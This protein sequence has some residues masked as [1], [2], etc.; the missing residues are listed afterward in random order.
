MP[1]EVD[2]LGENEDYVYTDKNGAEWKYTF[3]FPGV[4]KAYEILDNATM[5]NGQIAR[6]IY[7]D[8]M[9]QN[10]IVE[11]AGLTLDDFDDRPGLDELYTALDLFL[12]AR[13]SD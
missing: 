4:R 5:A 10:V 8:E 3:Q 13:I 7:F 11:P 1:V 12:G 9:I 6:S 2:R